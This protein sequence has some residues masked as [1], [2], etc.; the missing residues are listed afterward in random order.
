MMHYRRAGGRVHARGPLLSH[1]PLSPMFPVCQQGVYA[2]KIFKKIIIMM[3]YYI[4]EEIKVSLCQAIFKPVQA[5][6]LHFLL[7]VV[8]KYNR[9]KC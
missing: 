6:E 4:T 5:S 7:E 2:K 1:P 8:K 9:L 3:H